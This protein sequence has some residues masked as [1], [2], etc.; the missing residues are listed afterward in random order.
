MKMKPIL[1]KLIQNKRIQNMNT[2]N[3][4]TLRL[5]RRTRELLIKAENLGVNPEPY[6]QSAAQVVQEKGKTKICANTA[7]RPLRLAI[8]LAERNQYPKIH[9]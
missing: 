6:L 1:K 4:E 7:L 2:S 3:L 9:K 5:S 8:H